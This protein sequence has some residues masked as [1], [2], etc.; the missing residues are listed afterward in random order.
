MLN[1]VMLSVLMLNVVAPLCLKRNVF[2]FQLYINVIRLVTLEQM[3]FEQIFG[4]KNSSEQICQSK[5]LELFSLGQMAFVQMPFEQ[6][7]FGTFRK[8]Y[9]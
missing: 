2:N 7:A 9:L 3:P 4:K 1:V 6:N 5:S 8:K